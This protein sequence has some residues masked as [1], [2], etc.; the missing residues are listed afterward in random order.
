MKRK[1]F[2]KIGGAETALFC[3]KEFLNFGRFDGAYQSFGT[4]SLDKHRTNSL[5]IKAVIIKVH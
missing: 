3:I 5:R 1:F 2:V 4:V